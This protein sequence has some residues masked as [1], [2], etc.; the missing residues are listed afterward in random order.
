[1]PKRLLFVLLVS[2]CTVAS[3]QTWEVGVGVGGAGYIGDL[4]TNPVK[5][6]GL[7][8]G[9]FFKRNFNGYLAARLN[10]AAG[11]ISGYDSKSNDQQQRDRNLSFTDPLKEASLV[12][13][14]NFMKY[15]P[16]A[17]KNK[18]TPYIFVGGGITQYTPRT[19]YKGGTYSLRDIMTEGQS[20]PYKKSAIVVPYGA[21]F[22]YN[23]AG[24]WTVGAELGYRYTNT[25][26][27]DDVS[28]VYPDKSKLVTAPQ[29]VLSDRSGENTGVFTGSPGSQRGDFKAHDTYM[30]GWFTLSYT[31]VT[32]KCYYE[33]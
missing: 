27:L 20:I 24:K 26:Y 14:F 30:F 32:Q 1:M 21:G 9:L 25:D 7:S 16:D 4:N 12:A 13:E 19:K 31:F 11:Q 3:A 15:I 18:Y 22:K 2:I 5:P 6:S 10:L 28:G 17:G 33:N 23:F 8:G 29:K